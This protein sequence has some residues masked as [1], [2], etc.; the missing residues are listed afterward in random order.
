MLEGPGVIKHIWLTS[1]AGGVNELNALS[2][3]IYWDGREEPGVEVPLGEFFAV[4]Q[5]KPAV[6]ESLPVQVSPTG[7]LTCYW[8][9]P[10]A[11]S[12]RIV[13]TNDNPDRQSGL[14]WQVDWVELDAL[15]PDTALLPR[16]LPAGVPGGDGPGLPDRRH[17]RAAGSTSAR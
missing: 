2:L 1:H 5:G 15:P 7:S 10:F 6:V 4:G 16:A 12:A 13:I 9:M 3:R 8:R 11:Q 14:Y 17:R